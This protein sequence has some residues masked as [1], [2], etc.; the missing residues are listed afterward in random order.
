MAWEW[1]GATATA[2]V[3]IAGATFTWLGA[4]TGSNTQVRLAEAQHEHDRQTRLLDERRQVFTACI[5]AMEALD[6]ALF[7]AGSTQT[8]LGQP[9]AGQPAY[10]ETNAMVEAYRVLAAK[11][12]EVRLIGSTAVRDAAVDVMKDAVA[13]CKQATSGADYDL[14]SVKISE[15]LIR[16]DPWFLPACSPRPDALRSAWSYRTHAGNVWTRGT[17]V[18]PATHPSMSRMARTNPWAARRPCPLQSLW[19]QYSTG[20]SPSLGLLE[21]GRLINKRRHSG[22]CLSSHLRAQVRLLLSWI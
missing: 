14:L 12:Q 10:P 11:A 1:V 15:A 2:A 4:R 9:A 22:A 13:R 20:L 16:R 5:A 19:D 18:W 6:R 21:T 8:R 17:P 3:G 7:E